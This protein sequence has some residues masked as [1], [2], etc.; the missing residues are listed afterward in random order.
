MNSSA[1]AQAANIPNPSIS[2]AS[3]VS[4]SL[5]TKQYKYRRGQNVDIR[6]FDTLSIGAYYDYIIPSEFILDPN[7]DVSGSW[8]PNK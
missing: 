6:D 7:D 2:Y 5:S 3:N 1:Y 4:N 8:E